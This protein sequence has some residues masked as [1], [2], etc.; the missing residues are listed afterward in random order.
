MS[1]SL[2]DSRVTHRW[3]SSG[4]TPPRMNRCPRRD[5]ER[6][7]LGVVPNLKTTAELF[8]SVELAAE[9]EALKVQ[10]AAVVGTQRAPT[11]IRPFAIT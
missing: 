6:A 11:P 7:K 8:A 9:I 1:R 3:N 4:L 5:S 10:L 2:I